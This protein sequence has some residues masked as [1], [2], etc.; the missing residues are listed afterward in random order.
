MGTES[1]LLMSK[2]DFREDLQVDHKTAERWLKALEN[3]YVCFRVTPYGP[4]RVRAV[5]KERKLKLG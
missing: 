4:P 1:T 3:M 5:K 2:V